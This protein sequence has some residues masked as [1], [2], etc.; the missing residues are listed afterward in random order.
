MARMRRRPALLAGAAALVLALAGCS[1]DGAGEETPTPQT[2]AERLDAARATLEATDA[3]TINL[4]STGVP[5][6][7]NGVRSAVGTGVVDGDTITFAGDVEARITGITATVGLICIGEDAY[8]KLFTPDFAPVDL[9]ELGAPNPTTFL[10]PETGIASLMEATSDLTEGDRQREGREILTEVTG[11][12]PGEKVEGL[13]RLGG[14]G[15]TFDVAYG[16]TDDNE[17][18]RAVIEGEFYE[19]TMSTYT[20]ILTDYG[21]AVPIER[22]TGTSTSTE[23]GTETSTETSTGTS[24]DAPAEP[25]ATATS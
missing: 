20:L 13:L 22:P 19:G 24:T 12:L 18:R 7:V 4:T 5:T 17:L 9:E 15:L 23:T 14:P 8:M 10:E 1:E 6:D 3:L 16:L 2:A 25:T 11:T 21:Q